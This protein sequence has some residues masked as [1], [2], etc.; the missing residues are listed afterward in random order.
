MPHAASE[1]DLAAVLEAEQVHEDAP[2]V[3]HDVG[4]RGAE[5]GDEPPVR[6][7]LD[8]LALRVAHLVEPGVA[9]L[10]LDVR[11]RPAPSRRDRLAQTLIAGC[12]IETAAW[13]KRS[14]RRGDTTVTY[15]DATL[16]LA[17]A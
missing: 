4:L 10:D 5:P 3:E 8:V 12:D 6:D 9:W 15:M 16:P 7:R 13:G 14:C 2:D 1:P 11:R 17:T